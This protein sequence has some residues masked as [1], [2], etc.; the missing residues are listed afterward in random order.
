MYE[1]EINTSIVHTR[2][3]NY[4]LGE[5]QNVVEA[6]D[7]ITD[8]DYQRNYVYDNKHA[9][10]LVESILIGI[11]IPIIYLA[12]EDDGVLSVIDGQQRITSFVRYLR[13]EFQLV[14][15]TKLQSLNGLFFKDLE[16]SIQRKLRTLTVS[17]V[18]IEK[19][20]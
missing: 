12:E 2:Q 3:I 8:P 11:P 17:A 6:N 14:G 20:F 4:S 1:S 16:K 9:S 7:I 18:C 10:L 19:G 13:N 5:L 15:L